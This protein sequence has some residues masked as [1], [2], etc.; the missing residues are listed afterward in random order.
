MDG[1]LVWVILVRSFERELFD[2][3]HEWLKET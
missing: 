3:L 1:E 2:G